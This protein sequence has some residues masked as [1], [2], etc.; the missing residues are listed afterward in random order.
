MVS[1]FYVLA[2]GFVLGIQHAFD[3]DHVVAVS[4]IVSENRKLSISSVLGAAWGLGHTATLLLTGVLMIVFRLSIPSE[5]VPFIELGIGVLLI[6]L[7]SINLV[8]ALK[9]SFHSHRHSHQG[10]SHSHIHET[11]FHKHPERRSFLVGMVHGLAGSAALMLLVLG[12]VKSALE[13]ILYILLFGLGSVFGMM[14]VTTLIGM[15]FAFTASKFTRLNLVVRAFAGI[16]G[17]ALGIFII[18]GLVS[19]GLIDVL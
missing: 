16:I 14:I 5:I 10:L 9:I 7:G 12:T 19:Q 17:V 13:G 15:P 8:K 1:G 18:Y 11:D 3:P 6:C 2:A 4:N